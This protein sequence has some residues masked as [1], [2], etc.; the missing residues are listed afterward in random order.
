[1]IPPRVETSRT[2]WVRHLDCERSSAGGHRAPKG[3]TDLAPKQKSAYGRSLS[4]DHPT[5]AKP[6]KRAA[7][8][9]SASRRKRRD[10]ELSLHVIG[11][12][13]CGGRELSEAAGKI[14]AWTGLAYSPLNS[15]DHIAIVGRQCITLNSARFAMIDDGLATSRCCSIQHCSRNSVAMF[16]RYDVRWTDRLGLWSKARARALAL[17]GQ[18][19]DRTASA[20]AAVVSRLSMPHIF[21]GIL[22]TCAAC[23]MCALPQIA[24]EERKVRPILG[25]A[26]CPEA[27]VPE[28]SGYVIGKTVL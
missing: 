28:S 10:G 5:A 11:S 6:V 1:M 2:H 12:I 18:R 15:G 4:G 26:D 8:G 9:A 21:G 7:V 27:L 25:P 24:T 19:F 17:V 3:H 22:T 13:H 20:N 16:P 14:S 23:S